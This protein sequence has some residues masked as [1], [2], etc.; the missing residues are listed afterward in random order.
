MSSIAI[1][2]LAVL[3]PVVAAAFIIGVF[4][5]IRSVHRKDLPPPRAQDV[6]GGRM[7]EI[8]TRQVSRI[9]SRLPFLALG[10]RSM[11]GVF[12][13]TPAGI[14]YKM[15]GTTRV[16]FDRIAEVDVPDAS[17]M[18]Y[19]TVTLTD[20]PGV[21]VITADGKAAEAALAELARYRPLTPSA[22]WRIA[23]LMPPG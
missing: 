4:F 13:V 14:E 7:V 23:H 1:I 19:F 6:D 3:V 18:D 10:S 2:L 17:R 16:P 11:P 8:S 20:R 5:A 22:Q 15:M 21:A 9:S 12:R